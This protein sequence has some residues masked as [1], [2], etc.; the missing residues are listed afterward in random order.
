MQTHS[1]MDITSIEQ[2]ITCPI[3]QEIMVDPVTGIDGHTYERAAIVRALNIKNES[4]MTRQYMTIYDIK[5]NP[6]IKF[7]CDTYHKSNLGTTSSS[8]NSTLPKHITTT[9]P[10]INLDSNLYHCYD[11]SLSNSMPSKYLHLC[12]SIDEST[13]PT[14]VQAP[15]LSQDIVLVIDRSGSMNAEV[16]AKDGDG[17]N[18]ESGMSIQ[19]IVNHAAKTVIKTLDTNSRLAVVA[20]DNDVINILELTLMT[21]INK[22]NAIDKL[23]DIIPRGQTN[24]WGG[25]QNAIQILENRLDK[26]RN[27]AIIMLTDGN[28]NISPSRGE[29]ETLK[30]LRNK[31]NFHTPL[32]NFGFGYS[33]KKNLLY[34]MSKFSGGANG[35]IPDG[36]MIATVF[37]NF[38]STILCTVFIDLKLYINTDQID[39]IG[40]FASKYD[41]EKE[42]Y[43][44]DIGSIQIGQNRDIILSAKD[45]DISFEYYYTYVL[46]NTIIKSKNFIHTPNPITFLSEE[47]STPH[48]D[49]FKLV[50]TIRQLINNCSRELYSENEKI[51]QEMKNILESHQHLSNLSKGM[52]TNLIGNDNEKGQIDLAIDIRYFQRWGNFYLDQLSRSLNQQIKP[53]F[54][55][56]ACAF[57]GT[58]FIDIVDKASD[59]F[60]NL[61]PPKTSLIRPNRYASWGVNTGFTGNYTPA[62]RGLG[63]DP[64]SSTP[65]FT[66]S[67]FNNVGNGCFISTTKI[68]MSDKSLKNINL[69]T[70]GDEVYTLSNPYNSDGHIQPARVIALVKINCTNKSKSISYIG[71]LGVTPWHPIIN[72]GKWVYPESITPSKIIECDAVYNLI[73][74]NGHSINAN[75]VWAITL[76][77][78]YNIGILHHEYFGTNRIIND[79]M[80]KPGWLDG[81]VIIHDTDFIR[82]N[83]TNSIIGMKKSNHNLMSADDSYNY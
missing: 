14:T 11:S 67:A 47:K 9:S 51:F 62:Y 21:D 32:Y 41:T 23:N 60:D 22:I 43:V 3:T 25:I 24:I 12:F 10:T 63:A 16:E 19:D 7:L 31:N 83:N 77:H 37:C 15:H 2:A 82:D 30:N 18:L 29:V 40:D 53:N 44:Y 45:S 71:D 33:L 13:M 68:L 59:I 75:G 5:L 17:N 72:N 49:R 79:L 35:H 80:L 76:G 38:I 48:I 65:S 27:S 34:D 74:S 61:P 28:P 52:L 26:T 66:M 39:L 50:E 46:G 20:F 6:S 1:N 73:L 57:G 36:G 4:P 8:S 78:N 69:L 81:T 55:D 54:K 70:P 64:I 42:M 58:T 56:S